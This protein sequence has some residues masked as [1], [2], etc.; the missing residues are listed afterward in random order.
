MKTLSMISALALV[1]VALPAAAQDDATPLKI[2]IVDMDRVVM[3]SELGKASQGRV[4]Q[5]IQTKLNELQ[6]EGQA[7]EQERVTLENQRSVLSAQAYTSRR[8]ELEQRMLAFRQRSEAADRELDSMRQEETRKFLLE[9]IP[10]IQQIGNEGEFT[11]ILDRNN[12]GVLFFDTAID[13][14]DQV[15]QALNEKSQADAG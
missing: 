4:D 8:N 13:I 15:L 2:A 7:L 10:V 3:Q 9:A 6:Q 14:T 11:L 1:I 5:Y 12:S